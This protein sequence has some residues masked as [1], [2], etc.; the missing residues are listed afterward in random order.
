VVA[1]G[2][3][4]LT[5]RSLPEYCDSLARETMKNHEKRFADRIKSIKDA[6]NG[7]NNAAA[8]FALA[9]KNAWGE[10]DKS[11]TEYG[12]RLSHTVQEATQNIIRKDP[13]ST[14]REAELFQQESVDALNKIIVTVRKY[15]PKMHRSLR[16]E[17]AA[18]NGALA[19]LEKAT[20]NLEVAL[21]DS[22]GLKIEVLQREIQL[23]LQRQNELIRLQ[24]GVQQI[25]D[26]LNQIELQDSVLHSEMQLLTSGPDFQELRHYEDVLRAK[27]DEIRQFFQ[28]VSKP[29]LKLERLASMK[30]GLSVDLRA[31]RN[32]IENPVATV[33]TGQAFSTVQ[34]LTSLEDA[35]RNNELDVEE[36]R[37]RRAEE[38]VKLAKEGAVD[39]MRGEYLALQ[40]NI[41]ETVRQLK[42][43]GQLQQKDKLDA[44]L[45]E[46][47]AKKEKL[48]TSQREQQRRI[49]EV[50]G[51]IQ[52]QKASI[53]ASISR[54]FHQ[55]ISLII[56]K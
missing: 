30:E 8:R 34:L 51:L 46:N 54:T 5:V 9:V 24:S 45:E 25:S 38:V 39:E 35:L 1:L 4:E 44:L 13:G 14:F 29:L 27:E 12:M 21:D 48:L 28:P 49:D 19:R 52:K 3:K 37:R 47:H 41:Q 50:N 20:R 56:E 15:V 55:S 26:E 43:K 40:A 6:S 53:E 36:R 2:A 31:L 32:T 22:P 10:L 33:A 17:M 18:L 11:V 16:T 42:S 23:I 7:L